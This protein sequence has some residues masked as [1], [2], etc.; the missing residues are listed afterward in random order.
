MII[1]QVAAMSKNR[2]I[3]NANTI[4]WRIQGEQKRFHDL[5]VGH[6]VIMGRKT[7]ESIGRILPNRKTIIVSRN[8]SYAV[9]GCEIASSVEAALKLSAGENEVFI[10]GGEAIYCAALQYTDRIYLTEIELLVQGDTRFPE[11]SLTDFKETE[12]RLVEGEIPY[13][14]VTYERVPDSP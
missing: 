14:Y 10:A 7:F 1:S 13:S 11:F 5:T 8:P 9:K 6:S 3:G 2:I 4:P 12:R